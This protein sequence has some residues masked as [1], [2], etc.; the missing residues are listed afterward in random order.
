MLNCTKNSGRLGGTVWYTRPWLA[1]G[2][3]AMAVASG[4]GFQSPLP[5]PGG[6][7]VSPVNPPQNPISPE[8]QSEID[9]LIADLGHAQYQRREKAQQ[10]LTT[11]GESAL[12]KL[13]TAY[14]LA[15]DLEV[16]FRIEKIVYDIY[17]DNHLFSKNGF[18]GVQISPRTLRHNDDSRIPENG[19]GVWLDMVVP[20]SAADKAGLNAG[21]VIIKMDGKPIRSIGDPRIPG[22]FNHTLQSRGKGGIIEIDVL[23]GRR[24][25]H[26]SVV[27]GARPVQ[28][29][30]SGSG[31]QK[32]LIETQ[33]H[34]L[35]WWWQNFA[36]PP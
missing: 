22:T 16:R 28:N 29:Y 24:Q 30:T 7:G 18:L 32:S 3:M 21:D 17:M 14:H 6:T 35:L 23:R 13:R 36:G 1:V 12:P 31:F 27:L 19:V 8:L 9:K 26:F 4:F 5:K 20:D 34:F 33:K 15:Q 10:R 11:I 2:V 25:L